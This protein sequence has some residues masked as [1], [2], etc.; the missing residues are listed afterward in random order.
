M[1]PDEIPETTHKNREINDLENQIRQ[2]LDTDPGTD[3][4]GVDTSSL[5][6]CWGRWSSGKPGPT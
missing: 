1:K 6:V 4:L 2:Q 5:T 3:S